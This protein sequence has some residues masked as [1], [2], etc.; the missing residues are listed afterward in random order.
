MPDIS[1][2]DNSD[3]RR[4]AMIRDQILARGVRDE[5]VLNAMRAIP[6][7]RFVAA[8]YAREAYTDRPLPIGH[9]QTISQPYIVAFMTELL[10]IEKSNNVLEIGSG[11]GY[12][13]AVLASL[14]AKVHS[15]E[16]LEILS[17]RASENLNRLG[18]SNVS[19]AVGDGTL[20]S[21]EHAPFDRIMVTAGAPQVP[22]SL[23]DQLAEGGIMV[24]PVGKSSEQTILRIVRKNGQIHQSHTIPCRFVKLIGRDAWEE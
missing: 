1:T 15:I 5:S 11:T 13:T 16:R 12:Q 6:R 14:A 9:G 19:F 7:E 18:L 3:E 21:P 24:L 17:R 2:H 8:E 23:S 22:A 20:G 10:G 4:K